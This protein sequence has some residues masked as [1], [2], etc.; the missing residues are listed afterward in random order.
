[1]IRFS[2]NQTLRMVHALNGTLSLRETS[3]LTQEL[4]AL[5]D[6]RA[7]V[8]RVAEQANKND[9]QQQAA[10]LAR[11]QLLA[12]QLREKCQQAREQL[13]VLPD[14][15][16]DQAQ[17]LETYFAAAVVEWRDMCAELDTANKKAHARRKLELVDP[18][19]KVPA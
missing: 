11:C 15:L 17:T 14:A 5:L 12:I 16:V 18:D 3:D 2:D 19:E 1:M 4:T 13:P 6:W 7:H 9:R 10:A 8:T